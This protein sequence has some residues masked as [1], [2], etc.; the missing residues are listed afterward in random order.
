M[1]GL[2]RLTSIEPAAALF[3]IGV[4]SM[5]GISMKRPV[6]FV[7]LILLT[8][9]STAVHAAEDKAS[10]KS[11]A[12]AEDSDPYAVGSRRGPFVATDRTLT[13]LAKD[14]YEIRGNLGNAL[15]LQKAT[16]IYSC[17]IPP[18]PEKLSYRPYFVCAELKEQ[19]DK[20]LAK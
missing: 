12:T 14:G 18:D 7:A 1:R 17:S 11:G 8:A 3:K 10:L 16:S 15:V 2:R 13:S 6:I 20:T 9:V 4:A 5:D 19:M